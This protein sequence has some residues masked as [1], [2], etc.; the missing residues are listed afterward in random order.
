M[1]P[2]HSDNAKHNSPSSPAKP[3]SLSGEMLACLEAVRW[4][5]AGC[6]QNRAVGAAG[7]A[8]LG[9]PKCAGGP[10][11]A[12]GPQSRGATEHMQGTPDTCEAY[13]IVSEEVLKCCLYQRVLH[14]NLSLVAASNTS[15]MM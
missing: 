2:E 5:S 12:A 1:E 9:Q 7:R 15:S 10:E 3:A 6:P 8:Q 4:P 14:A 13:S 11:C